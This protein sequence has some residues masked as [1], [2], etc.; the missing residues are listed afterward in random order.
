MVFDGVGTYRKLAADGLF[1][2]LR[3]IQHDVFALS[4]II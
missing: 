4:T 2:Y 3:V 1:M